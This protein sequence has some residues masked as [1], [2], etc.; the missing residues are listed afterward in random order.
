MRELLEIKGLLTRRAVD[1]AASEASVEQYLS[2][3]CLWGPGLV[4]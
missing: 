2:H 3:L 1:Y 4:N